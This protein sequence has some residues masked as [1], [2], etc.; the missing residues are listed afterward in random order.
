[1]HKI[2]FYGLILLQFDNSNQIMQDQIQKLR[3]S[4][5]VFEKP[6]ILSG[7]VKTLTSSNYHKLNILLELR[8]R[9]LLTNVYKSVFKIFFIL[10]R[11]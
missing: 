5:T 9:I 4:S 7:K 2:V 8:T 10:S 3:Q 6:V 1:M 11:S